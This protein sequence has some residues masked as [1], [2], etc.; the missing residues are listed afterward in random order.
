MKGSLAS[1][2]CQLAWEGRSLVPEKFVLMLLWCPADLLRPR[3]PPTEL[4]EPRGLARPSWLRGQ[5]MESLRPSV[6]APHPS[7]EGEMTGSSNSQEGPADCL[8]AH[9]APSVSCTVFSAKKEE[10]VS[11]A[12]H[13]P[14][15]HKGPRLLCTCWARTV[16]VWVRGLGSMTTPLA[17]P[18]PKPLPAQAF[19]S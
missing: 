12:P 14:W 8:R 3:R 11:G 19:S 7:A 5:A 13:S 1:P 18:S 16:G 2:L 9:S 6:L 10:A 17:G 4:L 15:I